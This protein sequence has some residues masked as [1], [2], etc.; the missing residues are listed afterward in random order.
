MYLNIKMVIYNKRIANN[1]LNG[2][3]L[4]PFS[5]KPGTRQGHPVSLFLFNIVLEY[6]AKAIRQEEEIN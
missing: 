6:P 3:K 4:K 5:L 1:I 2:E